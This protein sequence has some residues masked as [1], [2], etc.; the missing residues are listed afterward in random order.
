MDSVVAS[1]RLSCPMARGGWVP[2]PGTE[3]ASLAEGR[4]RSTVGPSCQPSS[5]PLTLAQCGCLTVSSVWKAVPLAPVS[6]LP[7]SS[8]SPSHP[9]ICYPQTGTYG[10]YSEWQDQLS[11]AQHP[12]SFSW[13]WGV[14]WKTQQGVRQW[15]SSASWR[16]HDWIW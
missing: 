10:S 12:R 16:G 9:R 11:S 1:R 3:P 13:G 7:F 4:F 8:L 14:V 2:W 6:L 5:L 15:L